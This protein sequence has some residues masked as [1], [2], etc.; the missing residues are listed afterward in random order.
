MAEKTLYVLLGP[1]GVGKTELAL[2]LAE[3]MHSPIINADSRQLFRGLEIGTAAPTPEQQAR[4][5]HYFVGTL[6]VGNYYSAAQYEADVM[7]L[8]ERLFA[9][10]HDNLLL[11]GGSMLYIDA[12]CKGIDDIPTVDD[13]TR[14]HIKQRLANEGLEALMAE[15]QQLDP[16]YAKIVDPKNTRRVVHALEICTM[17]G[18]TY[19]SYRTQTHR[20]R[21]FRIVKIGLERPREELFER[22]NQ[23][24]V[25]MI[26]SGMLEEA[27]RWYPHREENALN[28]VGYKELFAYLDGTFTLEQAISRI[29]KNTRVYAK[30]QM[31][32]YKH[33]DTI[34]WYHP[35]QLLALLQQHGQPT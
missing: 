17:T 20:E 3:R 1:T 11:T 22:I 32:W 4:V 35:D 24:V 23:R 34:L 31:T 6:E 14:N 27:K 30:K 5:K 29:Q 25:D 26:E 9:E 16:E 12:V 13:A 19:T 7:Q 15:L 21:P 2:T 18:R 33:D 10:G 8:T 28:T